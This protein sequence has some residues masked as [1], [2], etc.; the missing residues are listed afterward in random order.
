MD[1]GF[2]VV[3]G[4]DVFINFNCTILDACTISIGS[5]TLLGPN[6]SLFGS[7]HPVDPDL[8]NGTRS[9]ESGAKITIG[10]DCW[11]GGN[12]TILPGVTIGDGC[13]IGATSVVTKVRTDH[14]TICPT[15]MVHQSD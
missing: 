8:R 13:T 15:W 4:K 3:T 2:N 6:V 14:C 9:P 12:V 10:E 5:R 1:Y 7:T 11:I